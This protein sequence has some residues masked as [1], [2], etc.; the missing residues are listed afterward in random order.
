MSLL[1]ASILF[2]TPQ[3]AAISYVH[4]FD[5]NAYDGS[6][7]P[8]VN[9]VIIA[10][11]NGTNKG[12]TTTHDYG[13]GTESWYNLDVTGNDSDLSQT[14]SFTIDGQP[15][16][17][18]IAFQAS[19]NEDNYH[20]HLPSTT[21][22]TT[23][24]TTTTT[25][26][27]VPGATT[28]STTTTTTSTSSTTTSTT[29]IAG[30]TTTSSTT[31]ILGATTTSSTTSTTTIA[32]TTT[33]QPPTT[34]TNG[35]GR[36]VLS[37]LRVIST[38]RC[39]ED[40]ILIEVR[41]SGYR[42]L[43]DA[44]ITIYY[45]GLVVETFETE[46]DGLGSY[47]PMKQGSYLIEAKKSGYETGDNILQI[48]SCTEPNATCSD[49][50]QNQGEEAVDCGG[51]CVPC[52]TCADGV[53]N[54]G[55]TGIDCGGSCGI[56][57]ASCSDGVKNQNEVLVDCGGIC[58]PCPSCADSIQNQGEDS[59]DCGGP[60]Q[61]C[62]P[63]CTDGIRNQ[64]E[65]GVDCGGPCGICKA[66]CSDNI[67]NQDEIGVDCGGLCP[68]CPTCS[69]GI[70]NGD[71]WGVDCG[72][73]CGPCPPGTCFDK[74]I[75]QNEEGTDCG[76]ICPPCPTC[77]DGIQNQEEEEVDCGGPCKPCPMPEYEAPRENIL[78]H[79]FTGYNPNKTP[80]CGEVKNLVIFTPHKDMRISSIILEGNAEAKITISDVSGLL[81]S[82]ISYTYQGNIVETP[83]NLTA[84]EPYIIYIDKPEDTE[85][86]TKLL[87]SSKIERLEGTWEVRDSWWDG[88]IDDG[89]IAASLIE[90]LPSCSDRIQN[91]NETG[92]DCGGQC[93]ACP[94]PLLGRIIQYRGKGSDLF[95]ILII[96]I[97][98]TVIY[99][100]YRKGVRDGSDDY[101]NQSV[102]ASFTSAAP[103]SF[104]EASATPQTEHQP[105]VD[106]ITPVGK[107]DS[108]TKKSQPKKNSGKSKD[109][110]KSGNK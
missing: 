79:F 18:S 34:T 26:T 94:Q 21:T 48:V 86:C 82:S 40:P 45:N 70:K 6:G 47:Q 84:N 63:T 16:L 91:Q 24:F 76:G 25:T 108:T 7:T 10:W 68:P 22:T 67:K 73:S 42:P 27:T 64:N 101:S 30:A 61:S 106:I 85:K 32:T 87:K 96:L 69:D 98:L 89:Y 2:T 3:A 51:P 1:I 12:N 8:L 43:K 104:E 62:P 44:I 5:G 83:V 39:I 9:A 95:T 28:T 31:T 71:E 75:N 59:V 49:N 50:I 81:A 97:I 29:T 92:V 78:I 33:I 52:P 17:E 102:A 37:Y 60:C 4:N 19:G 54:Q 38:G 41:K 36:R 65:I 72:G 100:A 15:A 53:R 103:A 58:D 74:A 93:K 46:S 56:C 20:L 90:I 105:P 23:I 88:P 35:G 66:S 110:A 107:T 11:I 57:R 77:T 99:V 109:K 13:P 14:V 80:Y 55:E